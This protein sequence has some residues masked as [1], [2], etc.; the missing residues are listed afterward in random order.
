MFRRGPFEA[1]V[2]AKRAVSVEDLHSV[3]DEGMLP[4]RSFRPL[5][6]FVP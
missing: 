2:L 3:G 4:L 6:L 5:G 1:L